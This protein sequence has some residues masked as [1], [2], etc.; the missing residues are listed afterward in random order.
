MK[1]LLKFI[2]V[3]FILLHN[4][5]FHEMIIQQF[6]LPLMV[7]SCLASLGHAVIQVFV[8]TYLSMIQKVLHWTASRTCQIASH[9]P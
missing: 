8:R 4:A 9:L 3:L 5:L 7:G 1:L 6:Y 2:L